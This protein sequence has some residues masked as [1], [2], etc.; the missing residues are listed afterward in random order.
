M[1]L[2]STFSGVRNW[3][4]LRCFFSSIYTLHDSALHNT[5]LRFATATRRSSYALLASLRFLRRTSS[6]LQTQPNHRP[7]RIALQIDL[8]LVLFANQ[9]H[10]GY[11]T[12]THWAILSTA[13]A[14]NGP[15]IERAEKGANRDPKWGLLLPQ[16]KRNPRA[17]RN[18]WRGHRSPVHG[19]EQHRRQRFG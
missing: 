12:Q 3:F 7:K 8:V 14:G 10:D 9:R 15:I 16:F 5:R 1:L 13:I 2:L 18:E 17:R 11:Q 4:S 6:T 19:S